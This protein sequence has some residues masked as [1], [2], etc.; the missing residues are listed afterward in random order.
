MKLIVKG[1]P[2]GKRDVCIGMVRVVSSIEEG[3]KVMKEGEILVTKMTNPDSVPLM[4]LAGAIVTDEGGIC[5]HAAIVSRELGKVC[6]VGTKN[7]TLTMI[8]GQTYTVSRTGEIFE[9]EL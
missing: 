5:C 3:F 6:V 1:V 2:A 4:K 7:A 8:T 9:G